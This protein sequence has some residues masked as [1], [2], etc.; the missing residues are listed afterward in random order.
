MT[1]TQ[2]AEAPK[3]AEK[4]KERRSWTTVLEDPS[5]ARLEVR[6][7]KR[8]DGWRTYARHVVGTGKSRK[9]QRGATEAHIDEQAARS[10]QGKLVAAAEKTGWRKRSPRGGFTAKADAFDLAHLPAPAKAK[11]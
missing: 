10:A 2:E 5:G 3:A 7:E 1:S 4:T 11:K 8:R 6:L 9:V